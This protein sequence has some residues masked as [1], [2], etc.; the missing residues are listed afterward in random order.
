MAKILVIEDEAELREG[1]L[2]ILSFENFTLLEASNGADGIE[3]A[4]RELPDLIVCDIMMP[5]VDGYQVLLRLRTHAPTATIPIIFLTALN[6]HTDTRY[7]MELGAEDY[8]TKPFRSHELVNAIR[9]QLRKQ[10]LISDLAM[11]QL[12]DLREQVLYSMPHEFRTPLVGIMGYAELLAMEANSITPEEISSFANTIFGSATRLQHLLENYIFYTQ[13]RLLHMDPDRLTGLRRNTVQHP[14][15]I[16]R[17]QIQQLFERTDRFQDIECVL[18]DHAVLHMAQPYLEKLIAELVDNAV[19]FSEKETPIKVSL[20]LA[21][22]HYAIDVQDCGRG[23]SPD[24]IARIGALQQFD[25]KTYEQQGSGMGLA[26]VKQ[27]VELHQG[28]IRITSA[29]NQGT[30]VSIRLD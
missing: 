10:A 1:I 8:L 20:Q 26:I 29:P 21:N 22:S 15:E 14:Q 13:L 17:A 7:G 25:R 6:T 23:M 18:M 5:E 12:N 30:T 27:I 11:Q 9:V 16:I 24:Q 3:I 2:V 19:K 28:E 4:K